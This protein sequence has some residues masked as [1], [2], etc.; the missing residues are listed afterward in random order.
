MSKKEPKLIFQ[1]KSATG[2]DSVDFYSHTD[3]SFLGEV[4]QFS[5]KYGVIV[6]TNV[7]NP[8]SQHEWT[9]QDFWLE[10]QEGRNL[11]IAIIS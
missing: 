9:L 11:P 2:F 3:Y 6:G 5:V 1:K 7:N 8:E 10:T 4:M